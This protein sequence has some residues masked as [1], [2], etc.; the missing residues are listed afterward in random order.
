[1]APLARWVLGRRAELSWPRPFTRPRGLGL[2]QDA[3]LHTGW[4]PAPRAQLRGRSA[5]PGQAWA[6]TVSLPLGS[7]V[8]RGQRRVQ[9]RRGV[10][11]CSLAGGPQETGRRHQKEETCEYT[12]SAAPL[13]CHLLTAALVAKCGRVD[14]PA[15]P[16]CGC[17]S[18]SPPLP[19]V[20]ARRA[21]GL[22]GRAAGGDAGRGLSGERL[23]REEG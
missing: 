3:G 15:A 16:G 10:S 21:R 12:G 13:Q 11:P 19:A 2:Q 18:W 6:G 5:L 14:G 23:D 1:M 7:V 17:S 4:L 9:I 20:L 8:P 22:G